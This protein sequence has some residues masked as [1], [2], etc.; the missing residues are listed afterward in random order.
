MIWRL[1][2]IPALMSACALPCVGAYAAD[3]LNFIVGAD[4]SYESNLLARPDFLNPESDTVTRAYVGLRI[5]KPYSLQRFQLDV[6]GN[7]YR[8]ENFSNLNFNGID[9]RAAWL[10]NLTPRIN[11]TLSA[12]RTE[13]PTAFDQT[14][15]VVRNVQTDETY[16]FDIDGQISGGWHGLGGVSYQ[17]RDLE[18]P[19]ATAIPSYSADIWNAGVKYL[20]PSGNWIRGIQRWINGNYENRQP[21]LTTFTSNGFDG[22]DSELGISW[23]VTASSAVA[24]RLTYIDRQDNSF[25]QRDFSGM[26][27]DVGYRWTPTAKIRFLFSGGRDI[28]AYQTNFA[29]YRVIDW[30]SIGENYAATAKISLRWR[31]YYANTDYRGPIVAAPALLRNDIDRSGAGGVE[32]RPTRTTLLGAD[33]TYRDRSSN[34]PFA[35][36][37]NTI[38]TVRASLTF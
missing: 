8:Y 22:Y 23:A 28:S 33:L 12:M 25:P 34:D 21:D 2:A 20:F 14:V 16:L 19:Q 9:Y 29:S 32:W 6:T 27:G 3:D 11:G 17:K 35:T 30:L 5:D 26:T 4:V 38:V 1:F 24:G 7:A 31:F 10:W 18:A 36:Y 15:G 37:D 13:M